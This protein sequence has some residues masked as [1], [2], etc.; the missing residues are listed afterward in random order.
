MSTVAEKSDRAL[1]AM[2]A[3]QVAH[4]TLAAAAEMVVDLSANHVFTPAEAVQALTEHVSRY[5]AQLARI[6]HEVR[7]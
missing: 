5:R 3:Y 7:T 4:V 1:S 6:D 2:Q